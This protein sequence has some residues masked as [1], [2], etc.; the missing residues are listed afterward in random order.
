M[1]KKVRKVASEEAFTA[2]LR[3]H[4]E[5]REKME[6]ILDLADSPEN[7]H[8]T[9]DEIEELL[10]EEV[11]RLGAQTM[12]DWAQQTETEI[13]REMKARTPAVYSGKKNG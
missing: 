13:G 12:K 2:K 4:P 8:K 10:I 7:A 11:R 6:R 1:A 5:L 3:R 9:A